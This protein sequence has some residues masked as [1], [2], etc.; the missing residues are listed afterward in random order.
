MTKFPPIQMVR[1]DRVL[2]SIKRSAAQA[3]LCR[4]KESA[5]SDLQTMCP[6]NH[7]IGAV[8]IPG[9]IVL[10]RRTTPGTKDKW[11]AGCASAAGACASL[12]T[13]PLQSSVFSAGGLFGERT[14]GFRAGGAKRNLLGCKIMPAVMTLPAAI[15]TAGFGDFRL[16]VAEG[17]I[18]R[19]Y[20]NGPPPGAH[21][22]GLCQFQKLLAHV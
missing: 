6:N 12:L 11:Q 1:A 2:S 14:Q 16:G 15:R 4:P 7:Q 13:L 17:A 10:L 8:L 9:S 3:A 18:H 22:L 21:C 5:T 19:R 20:R